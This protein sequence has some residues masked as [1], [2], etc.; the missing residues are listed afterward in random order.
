MMLSP[1]ILWCRASGFKV[2]LR[3]YRLYRRKILDSDIHIDLL[4][5]FF[6]SILQKKIYK[7]LKLL[8]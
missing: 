6:S 7:S 4:Q 8:K 3:T 1:R 5:Y 2:I